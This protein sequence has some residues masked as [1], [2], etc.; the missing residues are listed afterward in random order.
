MGDTRV[1]F[2][3]SVPVSNLELYNDE[4]LADPWST[5]RELQELGATV[6]L[7]GARNSVVGSGQGECSWSCGGSEGNPATVSVWS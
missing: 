3:E 1:R 2:G 4:V 5:Y 7:V 6:W